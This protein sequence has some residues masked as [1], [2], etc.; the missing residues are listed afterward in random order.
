[1]V[2]SAKTTA[3]SASKTAPQPSVKSAKS[4]VAKAS[5]AGEPF[6]RFHHSNDLRTKT[7]TLLS[8]IETAPDAALHGQSLAD[9]VAELTE[10]GMDYYFMKALKQAKVGFVGEQSA[11]LGIS[12]ATKLISSVSRKFIER[13]DAAQLQVVVRHIR[14]LS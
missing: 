7:N 11:R 13:M 1:M 3:K 6:L 12:G 5:G 4:P 9:L 14:E 2:S 10:V 8:T